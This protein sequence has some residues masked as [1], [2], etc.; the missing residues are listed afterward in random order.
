MLLQPVKA[1]A[2]TVLT[3]LVVSLPVYGVAIER[4]VVSFVE[5]GVDRLLFNHSETRCTL[6]IVK[7]SGI[8]ETTPGVNQYSGYLSVGSTLTPLCHYITNS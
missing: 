4:G 1:I 8:C 2:S 6:D 3:A 5:D 7:N